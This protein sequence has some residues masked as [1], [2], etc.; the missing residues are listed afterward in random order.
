MDGTGG[1]GIIRAEL[2]GLATDAHGLQEISDQQAQLMHSLGSTLEGLAYTLQS[3]QAGPALQACGERLIHDGQQFSAR[4]AD[5]SSM[6]TNNRVN[7]DNMDSDSAQG[8]NA[9]QGGIRI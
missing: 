8:F 4:F 6:M 9:V 7:L 3:D 1:N 2:D 5:H